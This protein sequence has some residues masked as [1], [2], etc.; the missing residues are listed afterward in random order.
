MSILHKILL[1]PLRIQSVIFT[2]VPLKYTKKNIPKKAV[3][4]YIF[5]KKQGLLL[6][7]QQSAVS[8]SP[9][10]TP[11]SLRSFRPARGGGSTL[12]TLLKLQ[13]APDISNWRKYSRSIFEVCPWLVLNTYTP[14]NVLFARAASFLTLR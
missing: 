6:F 12:G 7:F 14:M 4:F 3:L 1:L 13:P 11:L 8:Q 9:S 5:K 2:Q 10:A